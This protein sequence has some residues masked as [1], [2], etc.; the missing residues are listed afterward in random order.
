MIVYL[1]LKQ[2]LSVLDF[3]GASKIQKSH[4]IRGVWECE[5]IE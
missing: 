3:V 2:A 4:R 1:V 5:E